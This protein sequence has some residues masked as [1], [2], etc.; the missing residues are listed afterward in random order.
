MLQG[1]T[2]R[3]IVSVKELI[4]G[5]K[6]GPGRC[7]MTHAPAPSS[8]SSRPRSWVNF[9]PMVTSVPSCRRNQFLNWKHQVFGR[10]YQDTRSA[11]PKFVTALPTGALS[12]KGRYLGPT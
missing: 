5:T 10:N 1:P 2:A 8:I 11:A 3:L 6:P 9:A 7:R 12:E 4:G